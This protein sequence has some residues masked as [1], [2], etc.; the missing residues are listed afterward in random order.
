MSAHDLLPLAYIAG[1][2]ALGAGTYWAFGRA[3]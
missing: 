1:I 3:H 2:L